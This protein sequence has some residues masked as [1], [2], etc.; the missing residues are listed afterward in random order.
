MYQPL[1]IFLQGFTDE[2]QKDLLHSNPLRSVHY[3]RGETIFCVGDQTEEF[4]VLHQ[5]LIHIEYIDLWGN[6]MILQEIRQGQCFAESY[7]LSQEKMM[8][9]VIAIQDCDVLFV[10]LQKLL[11]PENHSKSWYAKLLYNTLQLSAEKNRQWTDRMICLSSKHIR[12]KI[13][14]FLSNEAI[15]QGNTDFLIPFN[16][17]QMADYL[18][19]ERTALSK[20]LI[21][22]QKESILTYHKNHFILHQSS[23]Y[24]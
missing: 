22:M 13:M 15:K 21:Q 18:N 12:T 6:R 7:A 2:E 17:Q 10:P 8:V 1:A 23:T 16:R 9:D 14:R 19:V 20:T 24:L 5:G 4:A 11:L 3:Q